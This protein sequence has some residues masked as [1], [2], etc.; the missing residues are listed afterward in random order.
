MLHEAVRIGLSSVDDMSDTQFNIELT[1]VRDYFMNNT[2]VRF[3][4]KMKPNQCP[5][6]AS[7]RNTES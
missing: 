4:T 3:N 1:A 6:D 2:T 7:E 5:I